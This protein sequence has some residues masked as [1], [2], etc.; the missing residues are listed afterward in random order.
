MNLITQEKVIELAFNRDIGEAKIKDSD[1]QAAQWKYLKPIL[2]RELYED[3]VNNPTSTTYTDLMKFIEPALA[4][5]VKYVVLE[6]VLFDVTARGGFQ[7]GA[8]DASQMTD[9]QRKDFKWSVI[10]RGNELGSI[11]LN[12]IQ[13]TS[14]EYYTGK[15][16]QSSRIVGG[17]LIKEVSGDIETPAP[18]TGTELVAE[19][20]IERILDTIYLQVYENG[21]WTNTSTSWNV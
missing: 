20:R 15:E 10:D 12:H 16:G 4:Y 21:S 13:N 14:Y 19:V 2:S 8:N 7:L 6:E 17:L 11:L 3:L 18:S 5:Y 9:S 1:I